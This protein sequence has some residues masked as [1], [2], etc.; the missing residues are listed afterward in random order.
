MAMAGPILM[1]RALDVAPLCSPELSSRGGHLSLKGGDHSRLP[2]ARLIERCGS[3]ATAERLISPLEGEMSG[4]TEGG[5]KD[6]D[7]LTL[8][9]SASP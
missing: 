4:R 1:K 3:H 5:A 8:E 9:G 2:S 6:R 7:L